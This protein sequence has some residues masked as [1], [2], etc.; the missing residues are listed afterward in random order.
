[1]Y[2]GY[3][4]LF[5]FDNATSY[6]IYAKDPL[7]VTHMNKSL[8]DQ[9]FFLQADWYKNINGEIITQQMY[10]LVLNP[11]NSQSQKIQNKF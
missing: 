5:I 8:G 6:A 4:L 9:Q 11:T 10:M 7:Q 1:M 2:L 3:E